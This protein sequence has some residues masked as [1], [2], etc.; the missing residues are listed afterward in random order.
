[1]S[2]RNPFSHQKH[3]PVVNQT[4]TLRGVRVTL[5]GGPTEVAQKNCSELADCIVTNGP[6]ELNERCLLHTLK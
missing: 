1:M 3:C 5:G 6:V 4:V 2:T